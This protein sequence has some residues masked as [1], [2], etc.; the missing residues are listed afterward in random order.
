MVLSTWST[1][2]R[3]LYDKKPLLTPTSIRVLSVELGD[4][5]DDLRCA[6]TVVDLEDAPVFEA[7][8]YVWGT[9]G[10]TAPVYCDCKRVLITPNLAYALRRIHYRLSF[11]TSSLERS[12]SDAPAP[13]EDGQESQLDAAILMILNVTDLVDIFELMHCALIRLMMGNE[14]SRSA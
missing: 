7:L 2:S 12:E 5:T 11:Q 14:L 13:P 10:N 3:T 6:F 1:M 9:G 4:K 8:S